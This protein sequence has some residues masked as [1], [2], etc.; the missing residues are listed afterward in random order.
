[1]KRKSRWFLN[2]LCMILA[3]TQLTACRLAAEEG[4]IISGEDRLAGIFITTEYVDTFDLDD[5]DTKALMKGELVREGDGRVCGSFDEEQGE[6]VFADLQGYSLGSVVLSKEWGDY[7]CGV[8]SDC[9][10]EVKLNYVNQG[11]SCFGTLHYDVTQIGSEYQI[12][13]D[14]SY[15]KDYPDAVVHN[16]IDEDGSDAYEVLTDGKELTLYGNPVYETAQGQMYLIPGNGIRLSGTGET[17]VDREC[18]V[19]FSETATTKKEGTI[20]ES[21]NTVKIV[22][23]GAVPLQTITF[24][25]CSGSGKVLEKMHYAADAIPDSVKWKDGTAYILVSLKKTDGTEEYDMIRK[26]EESYPV[27]LPSDSLILKCMEIKIIL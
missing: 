19:D 18:S 14:E 1:M 16:I 27:Y 7:Y 17:Q 8:S 22:Y 2:G 3:S 23:R 12:Y 9:F 11:Y 10:S 24:S 20:S 6:F 5:I 26:G 13:R 4:E 21:T 25:W 15:K